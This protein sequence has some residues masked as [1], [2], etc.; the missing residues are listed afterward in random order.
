MTKKKATKPTRRKVVRDDDTIGAYLKGSR[1]RGDKAPPIEDVLSDEE[2]A[3]VAELFKETEKA[4]ST[5]IKTE[6]IRCAGVAKFDYDTGTEKIVYADGHIPV[7]LVAKQDV[8]QVK[9]CEACQKLANRLAHHQSPGKMRE[10]LA[11][12]IYSGEQA[13]KTLAEYGDVL[14]PEDVTML[15]ELVKKGE[16]AKKALKSK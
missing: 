8:H 16:M 10:K 14:K 2:K 5:K 7:R 3:A 1:K 4:H 12:A 13:K 11:Q 6:V 15:K 9:R